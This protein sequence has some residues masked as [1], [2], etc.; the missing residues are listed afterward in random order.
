VHKI[1]DLETGIQGHHILPAGTAP[2]N[3]GN[4]LP[5]SSELALGFRV[6]FINFNIPNQISVYSAPLITTGTSNRKIGIPIL[7]SLSAKNP[8]L[9]RINPPV[10]RALPIFPLLMNPQ[11]RIG[12]T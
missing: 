1:Q 4:E 7:K 10:N 2:I 11:A 6:R 8:G 3:Y 5:A 12:N 9:E